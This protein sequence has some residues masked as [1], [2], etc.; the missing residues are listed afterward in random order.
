MCEVQGIRVMQAAHRVR[1]AVVIALARV[2]E[3]ADPQAHAMSA[4]VAAISG[5]SVIREM[6][7]IAVGRVTS[8]MRAIPVAIFVT[9]ATAVA[10]AATVVL[11]V[12]ATARVM[13]SAAVLAQVRP[14]ALRPAMSGVQMQRRAPCKLQWPRRK[15][16]N[17]RLKVRCA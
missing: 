7:A 8:A 3:P 17:L 11:P 15:T 9:T 2:V 10:H 12:V 13:V 5:T 6:P 16:C 1:V 14:R 4:V